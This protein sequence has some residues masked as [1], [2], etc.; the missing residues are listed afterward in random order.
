MA[1]KKFVEI[2]GRLVPVGKT[3]AKERGNKKRRGSRRQGFFG[4]L[5]A[6]FSLTPEE[7]EKLNRGERL[8]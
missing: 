8:D 4:G 1:K 2:D 7:R 6:S 3:P 5:L